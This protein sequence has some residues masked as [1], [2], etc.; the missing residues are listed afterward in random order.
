MPPRAK[1]YIAF[2]VAAGAA[3]LLLSLLADHQLRY[4]E[5]F[6]QCLILALLASTFKVR[7]PGM[8]NNIA[9]SFVLFLIALDALEFDEVIIIAVLSCLV[10]CLWRPKSRPKLIQVAF[11]LAS[12]TISIALAFALTTGLRAAH[13]VVPELVLASAVFFA[14]NSGLTSAVVA[15]IRGERVLQL[16][17]NCHRWAFPYYLIG[18]ILAVVVSL[19]ERVSGWTPALAMVPLMYMIY[20]CY[21]QWLAPRLA[22]QQVSS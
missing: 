9:A 3:I 20:L 22:A 6:W 17:S 8:K 4:L 16:W 19:T 15:L 21:G 18:S 1:V 13:A 10:Q 2:V 7:L 12:T 11:S 5:R 14:L